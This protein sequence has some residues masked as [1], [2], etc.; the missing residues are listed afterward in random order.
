MAPKVPS[1]FSDVNCFTTLSCAPGTST[2]ASSAS[3]CCINS[4]TGLSYKSALSS[5][6]CTVCVVYGFTAADGRQ[7]SSIVISE[8]SPPTSVNFG[9]VK[10]N[11]PSFRTVSFS[12]VPGTQKA[13]DLTGPPGQS[14]LSGGAKIALK[15]SAKR[16]NIALEG[17]KMFQVMAKIMGV[18]TSEFVVPFVNVTVVDTDA[19]NISFL[20]SSVTV[21]ESDGSVT[22]RLRVGDTDPATPIGLKVTPLTFEQMRA[23]KLQPPSDCGPLPVPAVAFAQRNDFSSTPQVVFVT[24]AEKDISVKINITKDGVNEAEEGFVVLLE[25][26]DPTLSNTVD[27]SYRNITLVRIID[28]DVIYIDL[29]E[30]SYNFTEKSS[31]QEYPSAI[32]I[33]KMNGTRSEQTIK[34]AIRSDCVSTGGECSSVRFP[35]GVVTIEPHQQVASV[36]LTLLSDLVV[37]D[38]EYINFSV[39]LN[40]PA[41]SSRVRVGSGSPAILAVTDD[42]LISIG[43]NTTQFNIIEGN[44]VSLCCSIVQPTIASNLSPS[45]SIPVA[46]EII[47][48]TAGVDDIAI[49]QS[50][51]DELNWLNMV[52]CVNLTATNDSLYEGTESIS[53]RLTVTGKEKNRVVLTS[54]ILTSFITDRDN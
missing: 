10:G 26:L 32:K 23:R 3:Q 34:V 48:N 49:T 21:M 28:D 37:E 36:P 27:L 19:M 35:A 39:M 16:N 45:I 18:G 6:S 54:D 52:Q 43:F 11:P 20:V 9:L 2:V 33:T 8:G 25:L 14:M 46:I 40:D 15:V 29:E 1:A 31:D 13:G 38:V 24:A 50:S 47:P 42:D 53:F 51:F 30:S 5:E 4:A 7:L 12:T 44:T 22:L 17:N 41:M